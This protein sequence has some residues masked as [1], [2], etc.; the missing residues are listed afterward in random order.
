MMKCGL[1][2]YFQPAHGT[3]R[4]ICMKNA[5]YVPRSLTGRNTVLLMERSRRYVPRLTVDVKGARAQ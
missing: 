5:S 3:V 4:E 1:N 2:F